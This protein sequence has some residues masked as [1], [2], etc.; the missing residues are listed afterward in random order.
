M[1]S[2]ILFI[3]NFT[4]MVK[5]IIRERKIKK[6]R[7]FVEEA[8]FK[9]MNSP[10]H[11]V[12]KELF[13]HQMKELQKKWEEKETELNEELEENSR[14]LFTKA[15][16]VLNENHEISKLRVNLEIKS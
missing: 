2:V 15:L 4:F 9:Y 11:K 14:Y 8:Y 7:V 6:L 16:F 13:R 12:C 5:K 10:E 3:I 1:K